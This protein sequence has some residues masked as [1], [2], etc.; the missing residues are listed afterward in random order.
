MTSTQRPSRRDLL[1]T[2]GAG[3]AAL[4]T[5]TALT[6]CGIGSAAPPG[7]GAAE[8][9]GPFDWRAAEGETLTILQTPHPYQQSF[10]PLLR[11][12]SELTGVEVRADIVAESGYYTKLNTELAGQTGAHDVFMVGAY[13]LWQYGPPGW[14]EDLGPWIENESATNPEYD[15]EDF[16]EGLRTSTRWDFQK[17][18]PLGTGAQLAIPWG[19]E[20]NVVCY[21]K[22]YFDRRGITLPETFDDFVQL[23]VDLT[24]RSENRYGVAFRGSKSWA[25]IHPGFMSQF[26][27]EG[28]RDYELQGTE[29]VATMDS[30][31]AVDFTT[32]WVELARRAGPTSWTTYEYPDAT[33]DLG[34]GYAMMCY[35]AD[36]AT[37][38]KNQPGASREAG[39][40]GWYPGPAGPDGSYGTNLWTWALAMNAASRRKQAA[41]L[42]IQWATGKDAMSKAV[43]QGS[44]A[45]PPR[46]SVFDGAFKQTL[47]GF[48]GYLETFER[49]IDETKI[50]FTPQT[51]F[52]ETTENWA[53][54]LQD[55]Y[56]GEDARQRLSD[57]ASASTASV[58]T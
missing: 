6:S 58:N 39:N 49:V 44:F 3:G 37:Y 46:Q 18:S 33:G 15:F 23:A 41:W 57:L 47:G 10:Q 34:D 27:R 12:F 4:A 43:Q 40:L 52:F 22:A 20:T 13:F 32:K 45:D 56:A 31:V 42:F 48:P 26:T 25:T 21:N 36:S 55:V 35:D 24:D 8:V 1:R 53:V 9:T 19:F 38:P 54:A 11:E 5:G 50:Q 29:L 2:L 17:G 16:F 28:A 14:M 30:D 7:N 51:K